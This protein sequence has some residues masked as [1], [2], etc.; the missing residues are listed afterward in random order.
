M[1]KKEYIVQNDVLGTLDEA[2]HFTRCTL[3][4]MTEIIVKQDKNR[5]ELSD[6]YLGKVKELMGEV[7]NKA[8]V[9]VDVRYEVAKS[10][11]NGILA[12]G[13]LGVFADAVEHSFQLADEFIKQGKY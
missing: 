5:A 1:V 6:G 10:A 9:P 12:N 4:E 3:E 2:F 7:M 11:L 8:T 13:H